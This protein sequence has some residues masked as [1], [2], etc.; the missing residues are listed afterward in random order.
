[1]EWWQVTES[2]LEPLELWQIV[3]AF[4]VSTLIG[5]LI[6]TFIAQLILRSVYSD[7]TPF[8]RLFCLIFGKNPRKFTSKDLARASTA[9]S[10]AAVEVDELTE[11]MV[12]MPAL[13]DE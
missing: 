8:F 1:M 5:T 6:G 12:I 10:A 3:L 11:V 4:L 13:Y 2:Y 7:R 9:Q